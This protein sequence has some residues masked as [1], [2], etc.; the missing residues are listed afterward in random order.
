M[1]LAL[2]GAFL[3]LLFWLTKDGNRLEESPPAKAFGERYLAL[4]NLSVKLNMF[5][6]SL[7]VF[8]IVSGP[9]STE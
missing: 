4:G 2:V 8:S 3:V 6:L 7:I 9:S 5:L 1:V